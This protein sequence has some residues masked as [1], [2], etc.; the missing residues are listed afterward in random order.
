M[1]E[2]EMIVLCINLN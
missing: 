2:A 1:T